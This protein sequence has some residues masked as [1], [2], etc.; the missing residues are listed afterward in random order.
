MTPTR[1]HPERGAVLLVSLLILLMVSVL[2]I[3]AMR[4]SIFANK[5]ATGIQA[6]AMTFEAAETAIA[7][8]YGSM[9]QNNSLQT[10]F[11]PGHTTTTCIASGGSSD[12]SCG[13]NTTFDNRGLLT[14]EA[15]SYF[16]GYKALPG[17][18]ISTTAGGNLFVDYKIN[19]LGQST[20]PSYNIENHHQQEALKRGIKPGSEIE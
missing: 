2:G 10:V 4:S 7:V 20:M 12:G 13:S 16:A 18:Q 5:V 15:F 8:A 17:G 19:I 3:S 14:A 9:L 11:A 1:N 6:D